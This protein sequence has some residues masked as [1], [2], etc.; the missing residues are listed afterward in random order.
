MLCTMCMHGI[1]A[2][3]A[4]TC[5]ECKDVFCPHIN[6]CNKCKE[7]RNRRKYAWV[8]TK[9]YHPDPKAKPGTNA[10]AVGVIGPKYGLKLT[11]EQIQAHPKAQKF[12]ML[13]DSDPRHPDIA[14]EG[15]FVDDG[16][17]HAT[18]FEP[19]DDF[20]EPN[21]GATDIQYLEGGVWKT[22]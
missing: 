2:S 22:L 10:N 13:L 5:P 12:R 6:F 3:S 14:Y 19:K 9:D 11:A 21:V 20:G 1:E 16:D 17:P 7:P 8:I 4:W 18:G 15:Y